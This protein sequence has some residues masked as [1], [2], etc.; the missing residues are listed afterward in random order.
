MRRQADEQRSSGQPVDRRCC[1]GASCGQQIRRVKSTRELGPPRHQRVISLYTG[2]GGL[3]YG[4][5][6][7]GFETSVAV[8]MDH[9]SCETLRKNRRWPVIERSIFRV[10]TDEILETAGVR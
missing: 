7:A 3:D 9:D 4:L 10:P 5:E 6:A 2:A 8:E 1:R